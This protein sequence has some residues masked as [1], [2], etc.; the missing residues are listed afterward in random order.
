M[1]RQAILQQMRSHLRQAQALGEQ[2]NPI[3]SQSWEATPVQE[4]VENAI[5][6]LDFD[7]SEEEQDS[8]MLPK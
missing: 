1:T 5:R 6:A 2:V 3:F 4:L 8:L 7:L